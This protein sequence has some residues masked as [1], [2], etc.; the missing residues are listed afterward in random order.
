[1]EFFEKIITHTDEIE[2]NL[3]VFLFALLEYLFPVVP[4]DLALAFGVFMGLYGGY[5]IGLIFF[6]SL[7][8]GVI[9]AVTVLL[10]GRYVNERF[11]QSRLVD[12]IQKYYVSSRQKIEK[13]VGL[14]TRYGFLIVL[15]NRFI[16]VLRGPII[17][18]AGYSR[19][20]FI[21]AV[22]GVLLSAS[23]F[24]L[25]ITI[26]SVAA[27]RNFEIIRSFISYYFEGFILLVILIVLLYKSIGC[28]IRR[29]R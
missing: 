9:G 26:I 10:M 25:T 3:F 19:I 13:A 28:L 16:P 7:I 4:G 15:A 11:D 29:R 24:N 8:G 17:F 5:S 21:R 1:M 18:A 27:G 12:F 14:I 2:L 22:L 20:N 6:S 23:L